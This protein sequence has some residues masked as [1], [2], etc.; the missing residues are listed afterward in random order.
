MTGLPPVDEAARAQER[1]RRF[2]VVYQGDHDLGVVAEQ[3]RELHADEVIDYAIAA[4]EMGDSGTTPHLH[5]YMTF[6]ERLRLRSAMDRI[7]RLFPGAHVETAYADDARNIKYAKKEGEWVEIGT[8]PVELAK[9]KKRAHERVSADVHAQA[10]ALA[11]AGKLDQIPPGVLLRHYKPLQEI[12]A[13]V[14]GDV[15]PLGHQAGLWFW[16]PKGTWKTSSVQAAVAGMY[17]EKDQT[18][19]WDGYGSEPFVVIDELS[20][21]AATGELKDK[22]KQWGGHGSF[23]AEKKGVTGQLIRPAA[24]IIT[25]NFSPQ[26]IY[27]NV[28]RDLDPILK[29]YTVV[30]VDKPGALTANDVIAYLHTLPPVIKAEEPTVPL[31]AHMLAR[32][33]K[34]EA[35]SE[36]PDDSD[37]SI[38][39]KEVGQ[40]A[41]WPPTAPVILA[42]GVVNPRSAGERLREIQ[43]R[44]EALLL[45]ERVEKTAR[46]GI[47]RD[48]DL[49]HRE[50]LA[51]HDAGVKTIRRAA[52]AAAKEARKV[53]EDAARDARARA[54]V[55][56]YH[57]KLLAMTRKCERL[58]ETEV[59]ARM[60]ID[61]MWSAELVALHQRMVVEEP[62]PPPPPPPSRPRRAP[63]TTADTHH[64][65]GHRIDPVSIAQRARALRHVVSREQHV[66][67]VLLVEYA[68]ELHEIRKY[69][70][71]D[72]GLVELRRGRA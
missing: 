16:G 48:L 7:H 21:V 28:Y 39:G 27:P 36:S 55:D 8:V 54:R 51:L 65:G 49:A 57:A 58:V 53:R 43:Y 17:Y 1:A 40:L 12:A 35:E 25:A 41:T 37:T 31:P 56:A 29:R 61:S 5:V 71:M 52:L 10:I 45:T 42:D 64:R 66:R 20:A 14:T 9:A 34:R 70:I 15:S 6:R 19:W 32:R 59:K 4:R 62:I 63:S 68:D 22:L 60:T 23:M 3:L 69:M 50:M 18:K 72:A 30:Y 67:N 46:D 11:K 13:K 26:E 33:P 24:V 47:G 2:V 38:T 44:R